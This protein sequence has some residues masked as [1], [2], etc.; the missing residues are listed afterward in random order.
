[1]TRL[2]AWVALAAVA[3][4]V[5]G[6]GPAKELPSAEDVVKPVDSADKPT[7]V[8]AASDPKAKE[9]VEKVVN[10]FTGGKP[11]LVAKGKV[12]RLALKGHLARQDVGKADTKRTISAVWPDRFVGA[13]D[14]QTGSGR[15]RVAVYLH[16]SQFSVFQDG[17]ELEDVPSRAERARNL[18]IEET[19]QHWMATLVPLVDPKAV[20][21]DLQSA[22]L[23]SPQ[24][25]EQQSVK[26]LKLALPDQPL[27]QL[28]F[29]AKTDVLIRVE[30]AI[31]EQGIRRRKQWCALEHNKLGP[32]KQILPSK[33]EMR[34]DG[35]VV[36][37]WDVEKWEF[38]ATIPD[39]EFAP[40][41]K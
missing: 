39:S 30:Y 10:V 13:D 14:T 35:A 25:G 23:P 4:V 32:D 17:R 6:C 28:V 11:E 8:P 29:D 22:D 19:A 18:V 1:M 31:T 12:S 34:H 3:A 9:Y 2:A 26:L 16:G 21:F 33:I 40:P 27:H 15:T 41:K 7:A 5:G 37:Q 20:A 38:P 24:N 36:E